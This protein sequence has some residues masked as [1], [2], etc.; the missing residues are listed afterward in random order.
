MSNIGRLAVNDEGHLGWI[1]SEDEFSGVAVAI[2]VH[3]GALWSSDYWTVLSKESERY[4][5]Q[6]ASLKAAVR[7]LHDATWWAALD[8]SP[9]HAHRLW[10][11]VRAEAG[12]PEPE[13]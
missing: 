3:D 13:V 12:I 4:F 5:L 7:M 1:V 10:R 9:E 6:A 8:I 11:M 2:G